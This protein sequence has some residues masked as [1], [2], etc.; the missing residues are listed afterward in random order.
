M[1]A[2]IGVDSIDE[3]FRDIPAGVRF[4]RVLDLEPALSEQ[5][6]V[7]H[8]EE[9][10]ARE[11]RHEPRALVPR[12]RHLRP[13][14]AGGR[15]RRPPARGAPDRVHA[16]PG[17]DEP[18]RAPGDLRVPDRDLRADGDGRVERVGVRRD[19]GRRRRLLRREARHG[20]L[21]RRAR[22]DAEPAGAPGREDVCAGLRPRG[23][24]GP[25][26]RRRDRSRRARRG[27]PRRGLRHLPAA[28]L[29]R[30]PRAG[31]RPGCRCERGGCAT[32]RPRRPGLARRARSAGQLR[33][34]DRDRR[35]PGRRQLPVVRRPA[36]RVHGRTLGLC[37]AHAR[38]DRR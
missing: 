13:L 21:P 33:V 3:L 9:L 7:A 18:G 35:G 25:A 11:R 36:L 37:A 1:L 17:R 2:A 8:L 4:D 22:R 30:L 15:R 29:L 10:A 20:P 12:G 38:P 16:V 6:I 32:G 5:E 31:A 34:R 28:E 14:R 19:D 23:G 24:R 27:C 26:P